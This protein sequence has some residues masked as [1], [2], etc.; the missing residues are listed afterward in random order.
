MRRSFSFA[1]SVATFS[2]TF[3][4]PIAAHRASS[5]LS[6]HPWS[7][8]VGTNAAKRLKE[9]I[10]AMDAALPKERA[11]AWSSPEFFNSEM[12]D[13]SAADTAAI[14]NRAN[15]CRSGTLHG[16]DRAFPSRFFLYDASKIWR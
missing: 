7:I 6:P 13:A 1:I 5:A 16:C 11:K 15:E 8:F 4:T 3:K 10:R 2:K 14:T 9:I 12:A